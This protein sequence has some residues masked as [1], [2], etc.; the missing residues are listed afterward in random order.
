[1]AA[2]MLVAM[3]CFLAGCGSLDSGDT[4]TTAAAAT[5]EDSQSPNAPAMSATHTGDS[6]N[7]GDQL[8]VVFTDLPTTTPPFEVRVADDGTITLLLNQTFH[9]AGKTRSDLEKEIRARYVPDYYVNLTVTVRRNQFYYVGGEVKMPGQLVHTGEMTVLKAVAAAQ[10]FTD[11][12][13][14]HKV[15]LIHADGRSSIVDCDAALED[16]SLDL[17]VY[18]GDKI[19][20]PRHW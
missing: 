15:R 17:P 7:I 18:P 19:E 4:T 16:P 10:G 2:V 1:M 13:N 6:V 11:F 8:S 3:T 9:A 14:H 20:V 12:A 5:P